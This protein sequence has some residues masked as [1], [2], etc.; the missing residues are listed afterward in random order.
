M[1]KISIA[2]PDGE[3]EIRPY[4]VRASELLDRLGGDRKDIAAV[5]VNNE[6]C[7]LF[8]RIEINCRVAPV[9]LDS[10]AGAAV[11]RRSLCFLLAIAA[12]E[13]F[14][15]RTVEVGH[16]LGNGYFHTFADEFPVTLDEIEKIESRMRGIVAEDQAISHA[17]ISYEEALHYFEKSG[18]DETL[19]LLGQMNSS[20]IPVNTCRGFMDLSVAPL[21]PS[22][23][24]LK[25][26]ELRPYEQG[27]ILRYP[28]H[29]KP[30]R[31]EP[32][33][34]NPL[35]YSVYKEYKRWGRTMGVTSV[36]AINR[37]NNPK[38][39]KSFIQTAEA[40]QNK[41]IA[42][43]ADLIAGKGG[44]VRT[45]LVAGPSSSG[46]TTFS[47]KL[48]IQLTVLGLRPIPISLDD[49]FVDRAKTPRDEKGEYDYECLEALDVDFLNEQLVELMAGRE[50]EL[51]AYDFKTGTRKGSGKKLRLAG[52]E[53]L[54]LEGIHGLNDKLTPRIP[55]EQKFKA[56]VSAL[57]QLN[58]DDH[59]RIP[60]TDNRLLRRMVRDFQFRGH[61]A[62]DTLKMWPSVQ[63]GEK[64]HI[65]PFQ[66]KADAAFNSA[67]DYEL[68]VLKVYAE[69]LL[70]GVKP[71]D[72][73]YA[74]AMRM[75]AFLEYFTPIPASHVPR[76]SILR[77][78]I[79]ESEFK[80]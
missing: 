53:I 51:P 38:E 47:K 4:G 12:R 77:E 69:P 7:S 61:S 42:E 66:N 21:V 36:G 75:L 59:N 79:G 25:F 32:F 40:L 80:Y 45:V 16:S 72:A 14:P 11:Y 55:N 48:A 6:L 73:E 43:I 31:L 15:A 65:F 78:F 54:I 3:R 5:L 26:F 39:I 10:S 57:T 20:S 63:R 1:K 67:L 22:T 8:S 49:Y 17:R 64:L 44:A 46:K 76:D 34:D 70:K 62:V 41:K 13:L 9:R 58:L 2:F 27:F 29:A 74:E 71:Y 56:Y 35:L 60:T 18:Q 68:S 33:E 28:G 23:G 30:G 24:M 50:T 19:L 37:I 52:S